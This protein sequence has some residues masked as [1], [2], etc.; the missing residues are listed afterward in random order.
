MEEQLRHFL[1]GASIA[2]WYPVVLQ[3]WIEAHLHEL[4]RETVLALR[5]RIGPLRDKKWRKIAVRLDHIA[6]E[7]SARRRTAGHDSGGES[8]ALTGQQQRNS[9]HS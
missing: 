3:S 8:T 5:S 9:S 1:R 4:E 2:Y 6:Q 7:F